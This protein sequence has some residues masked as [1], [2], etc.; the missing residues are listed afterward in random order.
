M[1]TLVVLERHLGLNLVDMNDVDKVHFLN[2]PISQ[3]GLFGDTVCEFAQEFMP[4]M[5]QLAAMGNVIYRRVC[6]TAPP[7]SHPHPLL[8]AEGPRL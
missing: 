8:F 2:S 3:A 7:P 4:V 1:V 5:E 6:Q